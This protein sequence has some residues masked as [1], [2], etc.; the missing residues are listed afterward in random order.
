V[1]GA[2]K[3]LPLGPFKYG[4]PGTPPPIPVVRQINYDNPP[5]TLTMAQAKAAMVAY[6][7]TLPDFAGCTG[8]EAVD[9]DSLEYFE[10]LPGNPDPYIEYGSSTEDIVVVRD[11][12]IARL[13]SMGYT[14]YRYE[15]RRYEIIV[16]GFKPGTP[17]I[18]P[19]GNFPDTPEGQLAG[20][21]GPPMSG[22]QNV[23][24]NK[25]RL[26]HSFK[27][28]P[29]SPTSTTIVTPT[30]SPKY[31]YAPSDIRLD[32]AYV[33]KHSAFGYSI[34][35][36]RFKTIM[37]AAFWFKPNY[38]PEVTGKVRTM[39]SFADYGQLRT[40][41]D[42]GL[43]N[44]CLPLPF[45][46]YF[47]PSYH[48]FEDPTMPIYG[49]P[50]RAVS[51]LYAVGADR[52]AMNSGTGGGIG[53]MSP[54]LNHEF[55]PFFGGTVDS[56]DFD[57][58]TGK[59]DGKKNE[60][61]THEW[62]HVIIGNH[63]GNGFKPIDNDRDPWYAEPPDPSNPR[64]RLYING[65]SLAG[66]KQ[67]VV[68]VYDGPNDYTRIHGDTVRLGGEFS[69]SGIRDGY[70]NLIP[71]NFADSAPRN[72]FADGMID[73]FYMWRETDATTQA[74][75]LFR[76]GRYYRPSM[77]NPGDGLYTSAEVPLKRFSRIL[78]PGNAVA[79]PTSVTQVDLPAPTP[80]PRTRRLLA[81]AWTTYAEDYKSGVDPVTSRPR[82][83][84]FFR[85]YQ[86][87]S[88]FGSATEIPWSG[89]APDAN[90]TQYPTVAQMSVLVQSRVFGPYSD[91]GWSPIK[92]A[93]VD[94]SEAV[95]FRAKLRVGSTS[96]N[97]VLLATP[98]LDD[99]TIFYDLST[100]QYL[101]YAEVR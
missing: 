15:A 29:M 26:C 90:G 11:R 99:V 75:D 93:T 69:E 45:N 91:E 63:F 22:M 16:R 30:P 41:G 35:E 13:Q 43:A 57:R 81:M 74:L 71:C 59:T 23:A 78:P 44:L 97:P 58:F 20:P 1:G 50:G 66:T 88:S 42:W 17:L 21:Y 80:A 39:I 31:K 10:A 46:L 54:T 56:E 100:V 37:I 70:G 9:A 79:A 53:A 18:D 12:L 68:H 40:Q 36:D 87:L 38:Y 82:L 28:D 49:E 85:D 33:E 25:F 51:M 48:T 94:D 96:L 7:Q 86:A 14:G 19:V 76:A 65:R 55:E 98:V 47:L 8:L 77:N 83:E 95:K 27:L 2:A 61:R 34:R 62:H 89:D 101:S 3:C 73:E 72:Y 24:P 60:Y 5:L 32:G 67:V 92:D 4:T 64:L 84:P 6:A 52:S